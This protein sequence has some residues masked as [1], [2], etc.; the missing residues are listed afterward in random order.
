[1]I[2]N[3]KQR[4]LH[5][6]MHAIIDHNILFGVNEKLVSSSKSMKFIKKKIT[7]SASLQHFML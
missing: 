4:L 3:L 6:Y 1:M 5:K 2:G 7:L